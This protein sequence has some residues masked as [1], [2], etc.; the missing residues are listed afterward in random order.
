VAGQPIHQRIDHGGGDL[1]ARGFGGDVVGQGRPPSMRCQ[2]S[3][4][5]RGR[6]RPA[7][8]RRCGSP[9]CG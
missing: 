8:T 3:T 9:I 1:A 4:A 7:P 5:R 2:L 6:A